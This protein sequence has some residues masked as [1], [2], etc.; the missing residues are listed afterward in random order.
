MT[1]NNFFQE[2]PIHDI[3]SNIKNCVGVAKYQVSK[4]VSKVAK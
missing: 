2:L 3:I 1:L 4:I